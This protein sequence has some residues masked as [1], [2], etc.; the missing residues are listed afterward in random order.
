[1]INIVHG[2]KECVDALLTH[3]KVRAISFVGSSPVAKYIFETGTQHGK[4]VQAARR[5]E[6]LCVRHARRRFGNS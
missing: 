2:G 4:R 5:R 6:E 3:P 1:V